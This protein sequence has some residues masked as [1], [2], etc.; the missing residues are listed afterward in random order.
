MHQIIIIF[1]EPKQEN[2]R[3]FIAISFHFRSDVFKAMFSSENFV[4]NTKHEANVNDF[5]PDIVDNFLKFL[6]SDKLD[7]PELFNSVDLLLMSDK[8][9]V[10]GLRKKCEEALIEDIGP[11]NA[12]QLLVVAS[13][14]QAPLLV[15]RSANSI[16][17]NLDMFVGTEE[18]NE[19]VKP[20]AEIMNLIFTHHVL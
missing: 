6:Y 18:W 14:I 20:S 11:S 10:C 8:Y 9:Q 17:I 12:I 16:F 15:A 3:F 1:V 19:I 7:N 2:L 5:E 13:R 4:E